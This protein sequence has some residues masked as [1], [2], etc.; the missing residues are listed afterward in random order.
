MTD[1]TRTD[2][3]SGLTAEAT[4]RFGAARAA[5][6]A[7]AIEDTARWMAEVAA[8][9]LDAEEPPAFYAESAS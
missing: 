4:R 5:A 9:P 2:T 8:F 3:L 1:T 7:P 6:L